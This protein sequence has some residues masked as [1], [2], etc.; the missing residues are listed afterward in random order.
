MCSVCQ[1]GINPGDKQE[2]GEK[3]IIMSSDNKW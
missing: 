3:K 2:N 1:K